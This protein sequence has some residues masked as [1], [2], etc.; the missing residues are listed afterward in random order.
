MSWLVRPIC[1]VLAV[2]L[3][4]GGGVI[5]LCGCDGGSHGV[6]CPALPSPAATPPPGQGCCAGAPGAASGQRA[7][8]V[9][10]ADCGCPT[11][12]LERSP[13]E[14]VEPARELPGG[15]PPSVPSTHPALTSPFPAVGRPDPGCVR[16]GSGPPAGSL[17]RHL[18]LHV[19]RL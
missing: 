14:M 16:A 3:L 9:S 4:F 15:V 13:S 2:L 5:D 11:V 17:R 6:F 18:L 7:A 19:L 10:A 12:E 8:P 1:A